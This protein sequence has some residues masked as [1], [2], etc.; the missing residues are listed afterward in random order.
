VHAMD[1]AELFPYKQHYMQK[2]K[3]AFRDFL[4]RLSVESKRNQIT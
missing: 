1:S 3:T 4:I 2:V